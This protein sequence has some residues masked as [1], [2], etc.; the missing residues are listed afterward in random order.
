M[1]LQDDADV[2]VVFPWSCNVEYVSLPI[3]LLLSKFKCYD[4]RITYGK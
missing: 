3:G 2:V 4:S 1:M